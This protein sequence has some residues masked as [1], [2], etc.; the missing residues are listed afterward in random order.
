MVPVWIEKSHNNGISLENRY[1]L[2]HDNKD[3]IITTAGTASGD[4]LYLHAPV[5]GAWQTWT[6]AYAV[7]ENCDQ[8]GCP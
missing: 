5:S 4:H 3:E 8:S 6:W 2:D 7:T 1:V